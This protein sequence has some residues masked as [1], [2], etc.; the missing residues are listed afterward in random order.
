MAVYLV[1]TLVGFYMG[2]S[3]EPSQAAYEKVFDDAYEQLDQSAFTAID[4]EEALKIKNDFVKDYQSKDK[5]EA[6]KDIAALREEA[7]SLG[8]VSNTAAAEQFEKAFIQLALADAY[9]AS[10]D[11][12][13]AFRDAISFSTVLFWIMAVMVGTVQG[14][15]QA[16]S[17]SYYGRLIPKNQSNEYYGFFDIFG[18]FAAFLGP[19]LYATVGSATG[20]SSYGVLAL[21]L[22][23]L[24]GLIL[25]IAG[26]KSM[27]ADEKMA[28]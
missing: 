11:K 15:I 4:T 12:A 21:T 19:F 14:G 18:K 16:V 2:Y 28:R 20:R 17:R 24:I 1:V 7:A 9:E 22:L 8:E 5:E 25:L 10:M 13:Q 27:D 26:K 3:L 23:F 6:V